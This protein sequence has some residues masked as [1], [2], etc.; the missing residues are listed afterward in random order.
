MVILHGPS[1]LSIAISSAVASWLFFRDLGQICEAITQ[2]LLK[3]YSNQLNYC[4]SF[5]A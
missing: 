3:K 2:Y 1:F 4:D 5:A